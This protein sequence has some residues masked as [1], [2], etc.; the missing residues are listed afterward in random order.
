MLDSVM[1]SPESSNTVCTFMSIF[2]FS[3]GQPWAAQDR[4]M[5]PGFDAVRILRRSGRAKIT[6]RNRKFTDLEVRN[7][8]A[9]SG[10]SVIVIV[11]CCIKRANRFGRAF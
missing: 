4:V 11:V 2:T 7:T 3:M 6:E 8:V 10:S 5:R 9:T 1:P